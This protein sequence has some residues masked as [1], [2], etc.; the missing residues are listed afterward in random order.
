MEDNHPI[1]LLIVDDDEEF[2][3]TLCRRFRR[4]WFQ[5]KRPPQPLLQVGLDCQG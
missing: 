4:R 1:D 5:G 2:R 3:G